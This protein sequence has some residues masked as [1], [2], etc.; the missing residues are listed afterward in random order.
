M[1]NK[2]KGDWLVT[3]TGVKFYPLDPR[4]EDIRVMDI[5]HALANICRF[6]GHTEQFYSVSQHS[7]LGVDILR[8][9]C[10]TPAIQYQFLMHDATEA[11]VG[12]CVRPLKY[13]MPEF[14]EIEDRTWFAIAKALGL[15]RKLDPII[16]ITDRVL[17]STERR[18][19]VPF[20]EGFVYKEKKPPSRLFRITTWSP[21]K[22]KARFMSEY[23]RLYRARIIQ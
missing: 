4:P 17:L 14:M 12:D 13:S 8:L 6:G 20:H 23:K 10:K 15:P 19:V 16:K 9:Q 18:D 1:K 2:R 21:E 22:T 7:C 3:Y 11:Y 5:A